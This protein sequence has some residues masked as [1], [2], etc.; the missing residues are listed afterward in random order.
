[1]GYLPFSMILKRNA[2][3]G[4]YYTSLPQKIQGFVAGSSKILSVLVQAELKKADIPEIFTSL[5]STKK[6]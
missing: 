5:I 1:M 3:H 4:D 6:S 2:L